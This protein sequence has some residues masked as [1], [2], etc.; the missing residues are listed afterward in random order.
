APL[1]RADQDRAL[2]QLV[3]G[4]AAAVLGHAAPDAIEPARSFTDLGF[5]SLTAV[6][7]R[8]RLTAATAL[9]L[10]A[11]LVFDY[12]APTVL[13][14]H[15]RTRL[16]GDADQASPVPRSAPAADGEPIAIIGMGC[17]FPGGADTP[18][19]LWELLAAGTDTI[20][21]LPQDRGWETGPYAQD[22][23]P[24]AAG[25]TRKGGFLFGAG[26]F[27][28]GFFGISPREALA[29]DPQ[30]RLL[31]E[32]SWEALEHAGID[33]RA[34]NGSPTG[35]FTGASYSGYGAGMEAEFAAHLLTGTAA[36]VMA[37]RLSYLL[38]LEGPALTVDT[39]CSSSLVSLHLAV[40]ALRS[41][42]CTL[43]LS[44][45]VT[46][47]ANP[48]GLLG[49]TQQGALAADG[50]CKA[51]SA[52]ADGMGMSEGA[53]VL[54]LERLSDARRHGHRPLAVVTGSAVNQD[55]ASNGL[56]APNGPAQQR[57]IRT[58]LAGAGL[59][60]EQVDAVE[61][62]GTGTV[63]GDPIEV[64]AL[65]ATY[66]QHRPESQPV[67]VGSVK[68]NIGHTQCAA[69]VAG[70]MKMVLA[71]Q[72]G[73]LPR[74]LHAEQ[75][76]EHVD[77]SAG[78]LRV[79]TEPVPWTADGRPRRAAVSSCGF[80]GTNAHAILEDPPAGDPAEV[81]DTAG[82]S[83]AVLDHGSATAWL[84]SAR[85][86]AGLRSQARRLADWGGQRQAP[87]PAAVAWS[88]AT[89]R[90]VFEQRAV[91]IG[92]SEAELS[93][94]LAAVAA[95]EPAAGTVTGSASPNG[96]VVFVFPGQG[97]QWAGMGL[98]LQAASPVFRARM[99]QC[100]AALARHTD[101]SLD[102]VLGDADA[103]ERV[104]V[105]QPALWA[106]MVSL[107]A[108][109]QA[110]GVTPDAV[111]GH[112]QGEIAAA[113]VA[114]ILSLEDAA[115]VVAL[116]SRALTALA[117]KGAMASL[118]E[119]A[120]AVRERLAGYGGRLSVAVVNGPGATVV[121]GDPDAV[122]E[123]VAV[124]EAGGVRARVLPVG[125]ASHGPQVEAIEGEIR[126]AL[127]G[128]RPA[129]AVIPM[130][131]SMTG[132]WLDGAEL[133]A[134]YWYDSLR[135]PVEFER[136]VRVL[137]ESGHQAFVEVSPHPVL[138]APV[139]AAVE[140]AATGA[141]PA[142]APAAGLLVT[143]TLRRDDGGAGRLLASLAE[144]H[145]RGGAVDW[146]S[147]LPASQPVELPTY[148]FQRQRYWP[149]A[150][151]AVTRDVRSAGL[152][153]VGH[154]LLGALVE[155]AG[156][157]GIVCTGQLSLTAQ[158]WLADY[159]VAGTVLL[160]GTA[161]VELAAV[162]GERAGCRRIEELTLHT[163][164]ALTAGRA[165]Q[166]QVTV[167][168]P[169]ADDPNAAGWRA[170]E[171]HAR[172]DNGAG[173]WTRHASGRLAPGEQPLPDSPGGTAFAWAT[174]AWPPPDAEPADIAGW[175]EE[176]A[177]A[178]FRYGTAFRGLRA[179]W[180]RGG[181]V[182]AEVTLPAGA[183]GAARYGLHPAL[184]E[185]AFQ[186][187]GPGVVP[188]QPLLPFTWGGVSLYTAGTAA[189][190]LRIRRDAAGRLSLDAADA[191]GAP[192][193]SVDSLTR[194]PV[195]PA[196]LAIARGGLDDALFT[197]DWVPVALAPAAAAAR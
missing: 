117:G 90:S 30:Q 123:L 191:L 36:S 160:P 151:P 32:V 101:W 24:A 114:G 159:A 53:G 63:L 136:A 5:D 103:L 156:G 109:W 41:G 82:D 161:F 107:A 56:T 14:A 152:R 98:A 154:P 111:A 6:E 121:S 124:C 173:A 177:A 47:M 72:H 35:V 17:R 131:S 25:Y 48:G 120:E 97:T 34:L 193:A 146:A 71:L 57:V 44:S 132:Q 147:V 89:T 13:A 102:D 192:V 16:L 108:V 45:G 168:E 113:V 174:G 126:A 171:I 67:Y 22:Q 33:P 38:G 78:D 149:R 42:E 100:A 79:L 61:A 166:V 130:V 95:G 104:D 165:V 138:T 172:P 23:D 163:P 60:P 73:Q 84:L 170:V 20:T 125:Y 3:R 58:A 66:G 64:Q 189:L 19:R 81:P 62:H 106:V 11:T 187:V 137:H 59:R 49:F 185:A 122:A 167:A 110:A 157:P 133:D 31:L 158:P 21:A 10:P 144:L 127:S 76:S 188:G 153:S 74:T 29:M 4:H 75:L 112:S 180:R 135:A 148:A 80:S 37:G 18:E 91:V 186:A 115:R 54:V 69:G 2:V 7:L 87:G 52:D 77:W 164:L 139:T 68:S 55:G 8:N 129:R 196:Q 65:L 86:A 83:P 194:R 105:V 190:R 93:A 9:R 150:A 99:A 94:G 119:P 40:Q 175:Y 15:L 197:V 39:A 118:A 128:L 141:L 28:A 88:L 51:F 176:F 27:D 134:G 155:L 143:G 70:V 50:R 26:E 162:A 43:A 182:F 181:E 140:A 169:D 116:R 179:A 183:D 195:T 85:S 184:L 142:G 96:R 12:P 46:I 145:V 1:P 178:G 92:A